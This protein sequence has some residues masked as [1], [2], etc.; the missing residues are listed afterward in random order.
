MIDGV[1]DEL[2]KRLTLTVPS[3]PPEIRLS[4][5]KHNVRTRAVCPRFQHLIQCVELTFRIAGGQTQSVQQTGPSSIVTSSFLVTMSVTDRFSS[6]SSKFPGVW[7]SRHNRTVASDEPVAI[8]PRTLPV[9]GRKS[10]EAIPRGW[11]E[12]RVKR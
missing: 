12:S 10:S 6:V 3:Y 9:E 2:E 5:F 11:A 7:T 4:P 8:V 1:E